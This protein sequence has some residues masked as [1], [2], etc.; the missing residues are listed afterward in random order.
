MKTGKRGEIPRRRCQLGLEG[1]PHFNYDID[2]FDIPISRLQ[3]ALVEGYVDRTLLGHR[4][5]ICLQVDS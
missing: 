2:Q 3:I 4:F 5:Y 1:A